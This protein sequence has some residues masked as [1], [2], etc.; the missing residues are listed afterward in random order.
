MKRPGKETREEEFKGKGPIRKGQ[1]HLCEARIGD[2]KGLEGK[3]QSSLYTT[4][5]PS[6]NSRSDKSMTNSTASLHHVAVVVILVVAACGPGRHDV[7]G[8]LEAVLWEYGCIPFDWHR[9]WKLFR[10]NINLW[11]SSINLLLLWVSSI[12]SINLLLLW[13]SSITRVTSIL[14]E[15]E[16]LQPT[17]VISTLILSQP[18]LSRHLVLLE[19]T[20]QHSQAE[21]PK[22]RHQGRSR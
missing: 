12:T 16:P 1:H 9:N 18:V 6:T 8:V 20:E 3:G 13:V 7:G 11:V 21:T 5:K 22:V 19:C 4:S 14:T 15:G 2:A 17:S 10:G